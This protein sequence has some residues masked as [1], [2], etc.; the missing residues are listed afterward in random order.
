MVA[1][2]ASSDGVATPDK[3]EQWFL[4]FAPRNQF[5]LS[6]AKSQ[7]PVVQQCRVA[8]DVVVMDGAI[9]S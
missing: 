2:M 6:I 3:L 9:R 5:A 1:A 4:R 8:V 7:S